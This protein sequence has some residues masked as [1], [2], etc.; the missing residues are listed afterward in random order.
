M[1]T[2]ARLNTTH[3]PLDLPRPVADRVFRSS[4]EPVAFK[5]SRALEAA[6]QNTLDARPEPIQQF[7][8]SVGTPSYPP[9]EIIEQVSLLL[10]MNM[11]SNLAPGF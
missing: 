11:A 8:Q 9:Q 4:E 6:L 7:R 10:A 1:G 5:K 3:R 2:I